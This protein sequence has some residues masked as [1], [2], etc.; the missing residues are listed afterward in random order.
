MV[1][2]KMLIQGL[3][4]PGIEPWSI[5]WQATILPLNHRCLIFSVSVFSFF[6]GD[7]WN[8]SRD[9]FLNFKVLISFDCKSNSLLQ[10]YRSLKKVNQMVESTGNQTRDN[11]FARVNSGTKLSNLE[12]LLSAFPLFL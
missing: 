5:A 4:R 7:M 1:C 8:F 2:G 11:R 10:S 9:L 3:H 6:Y 12:G